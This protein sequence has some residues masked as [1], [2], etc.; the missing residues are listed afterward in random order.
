[1][2]DFPEKKEWLGPWLSTISDTLFHLSIPRW[3][4][5]IIYSPCARNFKNQHNAP[6]VIYKKKESAFYIISVSICK[7]W[8]TAQ[9][10]DTVK[11]SDG[12]S[13]AQNWRGWGPCTWRLGRMSLFCVAAQDLNFQEGEYSNK[14]K[15]SFPSTYTIIVFLENSVHK[16]YFVLSLKLNRALGCNDYKQAFHLWSV[17]RRIFESHVWHRTI[18]SPC[19]T[20]HCIVGLLAF[21]A[22]PIKYQKAPSSFDSLK[23]LPQH[24]RALPMEW[25]SPRE[26]HGFTVSSAPP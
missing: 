20:V 13:D 11:E 17:S 23:A 7:R 10:E 9:A 22:L 14:T 3:N 2:R 19:R 12:C 5:Q 24:S 21:L 15:Y 26:K 6:T 1:M 8:D 4:L 25:R 16:K 18:L